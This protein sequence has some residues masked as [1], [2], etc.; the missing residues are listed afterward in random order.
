[1]RQG[2]ALLS[3]PRFS[4]IGVDSIRPPASADK[5]FFACHFACHLLVTLLASFKNVPTS[6]L[7]GNVYAIVGTRRPN[8]RVRLF[9][10]WRNHVLGYSRTKRTETENRSAKIN[11]PQNPKKICKQSEYN[12]QYNLRH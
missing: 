9:P 10:P 3:P 1:L 12:L 11:G 4:R 2:E 7:I 5:D 6:L 8:R